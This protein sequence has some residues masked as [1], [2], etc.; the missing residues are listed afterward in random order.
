[1]FGLVSFINSRNFSFINLI[2]ISHSLISLG[3]ASASFSVIS[4]SGTSV[5]VRPSY[6]L[7]VS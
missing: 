3:I 4:L 6:S 7:H 1:M 5:D 2:Q